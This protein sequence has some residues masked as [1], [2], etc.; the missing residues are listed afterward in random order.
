MHKGVSI[1][2][3][4]IPQN[5]TRKIVITEDQ[6]EKI[7]SFRGSHIVF[8]FEYLDTDNP[9]FTLNG[10]CN[11]WFVSL[12]DSL[13]DVS[14]K[15]YNEFALASSHYDYHTHDWKNTSEK[16]FPFHKESVQYEGVQFRISSSQGRVH[17]F[18]IGHVFY[19]VWFDPHHNLYPDDRFGG[20]K[21][22]PKPK[23]CASILKD[24]INYLE[25][26]LDSYEK[27]LE[28]YTSP[29]QQTG[30]TQ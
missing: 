28:S 25:R 8:S 16:G 29:E 19:V 18:F 21:L 7:A 3:P 27:L 11:G 30:S 14:T 17:G 23:D 5:E 4:K 1:P 26:E 10:I 6:A 2:T 12:I 22:F 15:T 24:R 20:I 9:K 13:R